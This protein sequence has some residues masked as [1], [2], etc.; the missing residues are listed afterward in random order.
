MDARNSL[1]SSLVS[2]TTNGKVLPAVSLA[3]TLHPDAARASRKRTLEHPGDEHEVRERSASRHEEV[4][5][6][7]AWR[8][9]HLQRKDRERQMIE[10][11]KRVNKPVKQRGDKSFCHQCGEKRVFKDMSCK[12]CGHE[13]CFQCWIAWKD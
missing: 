8:S 1:S 3:D 10:E 5:E 4:K 6:S 13:R 12:M 7:G 9:A 2:A 11:G